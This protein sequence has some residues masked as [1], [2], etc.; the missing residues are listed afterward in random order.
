MLN[1][2][3]TLMRLGRPHESLPL[4]ERV[5]DARRQAAQGSHDWEDRHRLASALFVRG[6]CLRVT[7]RGADARAALEEAHSIWKHLVEIEG[8][9]ELGD[10]QVRAMVAIASID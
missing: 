5:I 9:T 6:E 7:G 4:L 1:K 3:V 2:A 10:N 8:H